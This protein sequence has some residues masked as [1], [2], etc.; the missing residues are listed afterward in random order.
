MYYILI[1]I[2]IGVWKK[3]SDKII[4]LMNR[5]RKKV[6]PY[7]YNFR[8]I[9]PQ[10]RLFWITS[11]RF[12]IFE[13]PQSLSINF[14]VSLWETVWRLLWKYEVVF[15]NVFYKKEHR[16]TIRRKNKQTTQEVWN[17]F[18]NKR[19][20]WDNKRINSRESLCTNKI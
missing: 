7:H 13:R 3:S 11:A 17:Q 4:M 9:E 8:I 19:D 16:N 18:P 10:P 5:W 20:K 2:K 14:L 1:L 15:Q 6:A 12:C